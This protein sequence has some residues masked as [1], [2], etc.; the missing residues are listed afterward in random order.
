MGKKT[1]KSNNAFLIGSIIMIVFVLLVVVLFVFLSFKIYDKKETSY[2]D[3]YTISIGKT[4]LGSPMTLYLN[5]SLLF[6]GTPQAPM[7][8]SIERFQMESSL[9]VVDDETDVVSVLPL[10]EK[11]SRVFVEKDSLGY[12]ADGRSVS[13]PR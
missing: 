2:N 10:P 4:A 12:S 11:T 1:S 3:Q 9:L 8:I 13:I 6:Q 5:D 7:T